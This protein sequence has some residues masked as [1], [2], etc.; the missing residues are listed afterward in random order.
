MASERV[1]ERASENQ[2]EKSQ[3][4][5]SSRLQ[6][7]PLSRR[8]SRARQRHHYGT[9]PTCARSHTCAPA[10]TRALVWRTHAQTDGL[11]V[12]R[13]GKQTQRQGSSMVC[14]SPKASHAREAIRPDTPAHS[15]SASPSFVSKTLS[16]RCPLLTQRM[17]F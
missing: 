6:R 5:N 4:G 2:P 16:N 7:L 17:E 8:W 13:N 1:S 14:T 3:S 12:T 15:S 11:I 10:L 9:L